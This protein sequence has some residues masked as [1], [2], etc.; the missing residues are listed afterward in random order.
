MGVALVR[1]VLVLA[2]LGISGVIA[3]MVATRIREMAVRIALGATR[4]RVV[5][6]ML[7]DVVKLVVPGVIFGLLVSVA[8]IHM[9]SSLA[10]GV[11]EPLAYLVAVA[12]AVFVALLAGLPSARRA[13]SVEPM[14]AM[15]SE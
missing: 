6:L 1:I 4:T 15:R 8:L 10:L 13:A 11:V 3:F 2:A 9:S 12:I 5:G 7:Y 14:V